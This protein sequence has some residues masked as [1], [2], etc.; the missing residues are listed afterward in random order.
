MGRKPKV[1][2]NLQIVE[3]RRLG[4]SVTQ[5]AG[6]YGISAMRVYQTLKASK[7]TLDVSSPITTNSTSP[8]TMAGLR[9]M[10][11]CVITP[12]MPEDE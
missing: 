8:S 9:Y 1:D 7:A 10:A 11:P 12:D 6:K 3:D 4:M 5:V 2:R